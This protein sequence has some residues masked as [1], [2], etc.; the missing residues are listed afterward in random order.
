MQTPSYEVKLRAIKVVKEWFDQ[1]QEP[2]VMSTGHLDLLLAC[3]EKALQEG[4]VGGPSG[5]QETLQ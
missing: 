4:I 1:T 3:I 5:P 2:I